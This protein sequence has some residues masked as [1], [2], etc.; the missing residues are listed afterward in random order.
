MRANNKDQKKVFMWYKVKE[1]DN[2]GFNKSQISVELGICRKTVRNYMKMDERAFG[3]F[4]SKSHRLP[5]KLT[6]YEHFIKDLLEQHP[7]LSAAQIEDR[8][9][10]NYEDFPFIH[11]KTIYN[12]CQYIRCKYQIAKAKI[13]EARIYEKLPESAYGEFAQVDFG[14]IYMLTTQNTR[15]KVYFMAMVLCRSRQKFIFFQSSPFTSSSAI[16]AHIL[17]FEY[18]G[19]QPRFI[20]YDQ[21]RVFI[22]EENMG[23]ILLTQLFKRFVE[24]S[25]FEAI[26]CRKSDPESKGKIENVVKYVKNNFCKGRT[27]PGDDELNCGAVEWLNR[28]ANAKMHDG[29]KKIPKEQWVIEKNYLEPIGDYFIPERQKLSA[30]K[31]RKDNTIHYKSNFYTLPAGTFTGADTWVSLE[32]KEGIIYLFDSEKT[33]LTTHQVCIGRGKTI[34][35]TDHT[36]DKSASIEDLKIRLLDQLGNTATALMFINGIHKNK[37]RY[38]RD[39]FSHILKMS[40][41]YPAEAVQEALLL[42]LESSLYNAY[43]FEEVLKHLHKKE[44]WPHELKKVNLKIEKGVVKDLDDF[45]PA[46]SSIH[47]YQQLF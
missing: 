42:C 4:L 3:L 20:L 23:D 12:Y 29:I 11:S 39:N 46:T 36:R 40:M 33:L 37:G 19:G 47:A 2:K 34:R 18:F 28:T 24:S 10:E 22:R 44:Q 8:L 43:R 41:K 7:Y 31:V 21:D 6:P 15:K 14:Q 27:Y 32:E 16:Q 9:K 1:L 26:F 35:N 45:V 13:K 17:A 5:K 30:Y 25:S 38:V